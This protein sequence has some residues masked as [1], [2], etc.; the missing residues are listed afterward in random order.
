MIPG[1]S[2]SPPTHWHSFSPLSL[3][4]L[5]LPPHSLKYQCFSYSLRENSS[6]LKIIL[7]MPVVFHLESIFLLWDIQYIQLP[8]GLLYLHV[9]LKVK[10][11]IFSV[12]SSPTL[13]TPGASCQ[14][15]QWMPGTWVVPSPIY[16]MFFPI[17][18]YV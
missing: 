8:I 3:V 2:A 13:F 15:P 7:L 11:I 5:P 18:T 6:S 14:D 10:L 16:I 12:Y 17:Y 1:F 9:L 4:P